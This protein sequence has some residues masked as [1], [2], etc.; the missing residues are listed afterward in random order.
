MVPGPR[1]K[2]F[3][4]NKVIAQVL[5]MGVSTLQVHAGS[6]IFKDYWV[7]LHCELL[8]AKSGVGKGKGAMP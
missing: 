4:I 8:R 1:K 5:E 6:N 2:Y 3:C 7:G